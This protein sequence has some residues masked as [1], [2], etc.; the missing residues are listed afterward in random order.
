MRKNSKK[1]SELGHGDH[2]QALGLETHDVID[3]VQFLL[4]FTTNDHEFPAP[5][6]NHKHKTLI[7]CEATQS[8]LI[9][10]ILLGKDDTDETL[11][12]LSAYPSFK[13]RSNWLVN[14]TNCSDEYGSYEGLVAAQVPMGH[15]LKFFAIDFGSQRQEWSKL[16]VAKVAMTALALSIEPYAAEP[17]IIREGPRIEELQAELRAEGKHAEADDPDLH[18]TITMDQLRTIFPSH[19]DHHHVFGRVISSKVIKAGSLPSGWRLMVECLPDDKEKN[20]VLPVYVFKNA[21]GKFPPFKKGDLI[22]ATVW[23]QGRW[24]EGATEENMDL[25]QQRTNQDETDEILE[26]DQIWDE[27]EKNGTDPFQDPAFIAA[28]EKEDR[29][30]LTGSQWNT[31]WVNELL[32]GKKSGN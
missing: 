20:Y 26:S 19:A 27:H 13:D 8:D 29:T 18:L 31:P 3:Y 12:L 11:N 23:L 14:L 2:W 4:D 24:V 22:E 9:V 32:Y 6:P 5:W 30:P 21:L 10:Q 15:P 17:M 7:Q 16:G 28:I 25:W 1:K